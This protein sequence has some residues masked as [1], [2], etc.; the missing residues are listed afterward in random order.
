MENST[1]LT[2][3]LVVKTIFMTLLIFCVSIIT[4]LKLAAQSVPDKVEVDINTSGES[5]WYGQPWVWAIGVA[6]FIIII[7]AIT[8]NGN[9][10]A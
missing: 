10:N 8:R 5:T 1:K 2:H 6:V 4:S 7:V 9:R 3:S